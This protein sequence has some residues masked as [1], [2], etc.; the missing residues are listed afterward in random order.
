[1]FSSHSQRSPFGRREEP[2]PGSEGVGL[3]AILRRV[4]F[5]VHAGVCSAEQG[6]EGGFS[7]TLCRE[8]SEYV[9]L[10]TT[11]G[12][13]RFVLERKPLRFKFK[14]VS[15]LL[16]EGSSLRFLAFVGVGFVLGFISVALLYESE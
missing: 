15:R 4:Q 12:T 5:S 1:M 14:T 3:V 2:W 10:V 16:I 8:D 7:M 9:P 13:E 6:G 11:E